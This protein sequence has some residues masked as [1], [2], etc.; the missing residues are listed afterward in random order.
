MEPIPV[1]LV[2]SIPIPQ[3]VEQKPVILPINVEKPIPIQIRGEQDLVTG[4]EREGMEIPRFSTKKI[5]L[6]ALI[7]E[8][9]SLLPLSY[10]YS[11]IPRNVDVKKSFA[12][13][14]IYRDKKTSR[15]FM[16]LPH[17]SPD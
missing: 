9:E 7:E 4:V 5:K 17:H 15:Y 16:F 12:F 1:K 2:D 3:L 13:A 6:G 14:K 10:E 11:L 8:K